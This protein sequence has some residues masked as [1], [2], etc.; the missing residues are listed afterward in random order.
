MKRLAII[1]QTRV[2]FSVKS[3][4]PGWRPLIKKAPMRIAIV[5]DEGIPSVNNGIIA[6]FAYALLV[7]SGPA[8]P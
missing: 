2:G 6:E 4:G 1:P 8:T 3:A 7:V 5:G